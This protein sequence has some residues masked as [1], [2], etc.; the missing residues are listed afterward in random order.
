MP[1]LDEVGIRLKATG[2]DETVRD[3][4]AV[5]RE[6]A[7]L[8]SDVRGVADPANARGIGDI[9]GRFAALRG[10]LGGVHSGLLSASSSLQTFTTRGIIGLG[11]MSAAAVGF[12]LKSASEF[13]QSQIAF[14]TLLGSME[15]GEGL[16]TRL[17]EFNL[18]TPFELP[19]LTG[20]TQQLLQYGFTGEQAFNVIRTA[21]DVAATSGVRA[22]EN[23][24]R[25]TYALGQIR[26]QGTLRADDI[27]QLS[28]AGFPALKLLSEV[29]GLTGQE[30]RKNLESGL[31]PQI[32]LDFLAAVETGQAQAF[33]HVRGGAAAQ[34]RTLSGIYSNLKDTVQVSLAEAV[35]PLAKGLADDVPALGVALGELIS[36]VV[37]PIGELVGVLAKGAPDGIRLMTPALVDLADAS[38]LLVTEVS[39]MMPELIGLFADFL[40]LLPELLEIGTD[41]LPVVGGLVDVFGAFLD[42]PFGHELAG[43]LLVSLLGYR[44]LTGVAGII[45]GIAGAIDV[46][47]AAQTR[48]ATAPGGIAGAAAGGKAGSGG[49]VTR[50]VGGALAVV[51]GVGLFASGL[52]DPGYGGTAKMVGG[53]ALTGAGV[54]FMVGGPP[55]AAI[56]GGIGAVGGAAT[57]IGQDVYRYVNRQEG[58]EGQ[59]APGVP[60][61]Q[62]LHGVPVQRVTNV[63]GVVVN[64]PAT[65]LDVA[66]AVQ[67]GIREYEDER[68]RRG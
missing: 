1:S 39:P 20:A 8:G 13:E 66:R 36:T 63:G 28:D 6:T 5:R 68:D 51:P 16:F 55:G 22:N 44:A 41:L 50:G 12:G 27:R 43:A 62:A 32:A 58:V 35:K 11:A 30:I 23:L 25:I 3:L 64:N 2:G 14:G 7:A 46:L 31:D 37:P 47:T 54:G 59:L 38:L 52:D 57:S 67:D 49:K 9:G 17:Q 29:S 61:P 24:G 4:R 42:L 60:K 56:G 18:Q 48:N 10:E 19:D 21:S 15:Q 65:E 45:T 40:G 53:G 34:A 26:N 33:A